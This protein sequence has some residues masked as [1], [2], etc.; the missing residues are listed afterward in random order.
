MKRQ[1]VQFLFRL[2]TA[3][4]AICVPRTRMA[5]RRALWVV[6]P[7]VKRG[8]SH[9]HSDEHVCNVA[10]RGG[11]KSEE[12]RKSRRDREACVP[13]RD[14]PERARGNAFLEKVPMSF[15]VR[16]VSI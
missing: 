14:D 11:D 12:Y 2:P 4:R 7:D 6:R 8:R 13:I 1:K 16:L 3:A 9:D 5:H 10:A 15:R